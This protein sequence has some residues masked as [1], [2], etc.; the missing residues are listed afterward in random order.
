MYKEIR[1]SELKP[2]V[3]KHLFNMY[4]QTYINANQSVWF[5]KSEDLLRYNCGIIIKDDNIT[6]ITK[7]IL[8]S[9]KAF[10][11]FQFKKYINKISLVAHDGTDEGKKLVI[12]LLY[13]YCNTQGYC[14]EASGPLSWILRKKN[15]PIITDINIINKMLDIKNNPNHKIVINP[16]FDYHDKESYQY[17]HEF[18][19]DGIKQFSRPETLFGISMCKFN[20]KNDCKRKCIKIHKRII[21][22]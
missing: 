11:L 13:D 7:Y 8:H 21:K 4:K 22:T 19:K 18:Y 20:S 1:L 2:I 5:K 15:C 9:L 3:L 10:L 14:L 12:Q 16:L 17:N 6:N